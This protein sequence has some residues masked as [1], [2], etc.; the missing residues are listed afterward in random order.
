[1]TVNPPASGLRR[2]QPRSARQ[3]RRRRGPSARA[4]R[5]RAGLRRA[6]LVAQCRPAS[7][8]AGS[9]GGALRSR[10]RVGGGGSDRRR[11]PARGAPASS[12][13]A[14]RQDRRGAAGQARPSSTPQAGSRPAGHAAGQ[15]DRQGPFSCGRR[16]H[17]HAGVGGRMPTSVESP[18]GAPGE[19]P[20]PV[21]RSTGG[22]DRLRD[23]DRDRA[24]IAVST[25]GSERGRRP[26]HIVL[27]GLSGV[28]SFLLRFV[29]EDRLHGSARRPRAW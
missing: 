16:G 25:G 3:R 18:G 29:D 12:R 9:T 4:G 24:P 28:A 27:Y 6:H 22:V 10:V 1:M 13:A 15:Q 5:W 2:G 17:S 11:R 14:G 8:F 23:R 20:T 7:D 19:D 21:P 26:A